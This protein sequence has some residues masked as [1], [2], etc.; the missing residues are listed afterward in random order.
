MAW[1]LIENVRSTR[2][3]EAFRRQLTGSSAKRRCFHPQPTTHADTHRADEWAG[4]P[5]GWSKQSTHEIAAGQRAYGA[6]SVLLMRVVGSKKLSPEVW[7]TASESAMV[8]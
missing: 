7:D 8:R 5:R 3:E 2:R 4:N 6:G 1:E